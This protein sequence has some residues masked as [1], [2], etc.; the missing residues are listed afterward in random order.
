MPIYEYKGFA[1]SGTSQAGIIDADTPRAARARLRDQNVLVTELNVSEVA[2]KPEEAEGKASRLRR[3]FRF[4]GRLKGVGALPI[5]TRQLATLLR[6]GIPLTQTLN[7]LIEQIEHKQIEAIYRNVREQVVRGTSFADA[8]AAHPRLFDDLYVNM[9]RAGEASGNLDEVLVRLADYRVR[10]Q[11]I[12]GRI[13]TALIYPAIMLTI[14]SGVVIFLVNFVVPKLVTIAKARGQRLPWMTQLLDGTSRFLQGNL[15]WLL[16]LLL[17]LWMVWRYGLLNRPQVRLWWDSTKLRLPVVRDLFKKQIVSRFAVTMSTLLRSGVTV[18]DSLMI[19]KTVLNN[20]LMENVLGEVRTRILE[21]A[22]IATPLKKSGVFPPVV[23]YMVAVGEQTGQLE[24]MLD[25]VAEAYEE[26]IESTT[27]R[28]L[29]VLEPTL[30]VSPRCSPFFK[31]PRPFG[32]VSHEK[33]TQAPTRL[34]P[35][36]DHGGGRHHRAPDDPGRSQGLGAPVPRPDGNRLRQ[37]QGLPRH[38]QALPDDH[39]EQA[40][41]ER[42]RRPGRA[43]SRRWRAHGRD[44]PRPVGRRVLHRAG[45]QAL[46]GRLPRPRR[47]RGHRRR[48]QLPQ[49][50]SG[51]AGQPWRGQPDSPS[52]SSPPSW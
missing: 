4:E 18:L 39:Q 3:A 8:L 21:G 40:G 23:G 9:V 41:P 43:T 30:I 22:D 10:Q 42:P 36:R 15:I 26:E 38:A 12:A 49:T 46:P 48:H 50:R 37:V 52:S 28:T 35:D 14:G 24:E 31:P 45:G 44:R 17:A 2:E 11:R 32:E 25:R 29:A 33:A 51:V 19:V 13:K 5:Y 6:S 20:K 27:A 7:A 47:H 34:H 16:A 1:P